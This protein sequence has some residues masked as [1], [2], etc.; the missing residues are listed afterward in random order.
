MWRLFYT[1]WNERYYKDMIIKRLH[2][3]IVNKKEHLVVA[4]AR[5]GGRELEGYWLLGDY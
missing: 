5:E 1:V 4:T 2:C 3:V